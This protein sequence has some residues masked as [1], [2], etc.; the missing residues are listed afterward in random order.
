MQLETRIVCDEKEAP[1]LRSAFLSRVTA[2]S[3]GLAPETAAGKRIAIA[4]DEEDLIVAL[5]IMLRSWNYTLEMTASDGAQIVDAI[6][7]KKIRPQ[8]R[9]DGLPDEVL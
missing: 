5:A 9:A 3:S 2:S 1:L 6:A 7:E 8:S 4:G